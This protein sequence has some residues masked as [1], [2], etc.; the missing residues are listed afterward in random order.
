MVQ[1]QP[2][3]SGNIPSSAR[4][5]LW[6]NQRGWLLPAPHLLISTALPPPSSR[7]TA[8]FE[9]RMAQPQLAF[10]GER[11]I[12]GQALLPAPALA[13]MAAACA[14]SLQTGTGSNREIVLINASLPSVLPLMHYVG[15]QAAR[16]QCSISL[17]AGVAAVLGT[18]GSG[19]QR[20]H[21][22]ASIQSPSVAWQRVQA[23]RA[24]SQR[25]RDH[26][27]RAALLCAST[28]AAAP[29]TRVLASVASSGSHLGNASGWRL[30]PA[31]AESA[32]SVA[33][34]I[35]RT[36][37]TTVMQ[38]AACLMPASMTSA[39]HALSQSCLGPRVAGCSLTVCF[40]DTMSFL[41]PKHISLGL[42]PEIKPL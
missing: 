29:D 26:P 42:K 17:A 14:A 39:P 16:V 34:I 4:T 22:Q 7:A 20:S 1:A 15:K 27:L 41:H 24:S 11:R 40:S 31:V 18:T 30:H 19:M 5:T 6:R 23:A 37:A 38:W 35:S 28:E 12:S 36:G 2:Q 8:A 10:L 21:L 32:L 33:A 25:T 13:E 3:A 9:A